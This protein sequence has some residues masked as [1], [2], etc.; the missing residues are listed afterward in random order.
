MASVLIVESDP[1]IR[2]YALVV[3][4]DAGHRVTGVGDGEQALSMLSTGRFDI[5]V[6]GDP[7]AGRA[8]DVVRAR[9]DRSIATRTKLVV[10]TA[11][12]LT[13]IECGLHELD[14]EVLP[15]PARPAELLAATSLGSGLELV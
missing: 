8:I 14:V 12:D 15:R 5:A 7:A 2:C 3:F 11:D 4:R 9:S 1:A 6:I 10:H 13:D